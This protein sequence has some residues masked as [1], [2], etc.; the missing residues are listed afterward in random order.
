MAIAE[1]PPF[2]GIAW[3]FVVLI[4]SLWVWVSFREYIHPN[5]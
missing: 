4:A 3:S 1:V 5:N 2:D